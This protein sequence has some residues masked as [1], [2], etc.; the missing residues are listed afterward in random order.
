MSLPPSITELVHETA[1]L[2]RSSRYLVILT[3]AGVST[4]SGI[5][6]FRSAN[7]GLW[8][9]DDPMEVASLTS[10]LRRPER[11]YTW[12]RP[13]IKASWQ[14][15]PNPAHIGLAELEGAGIL[16]AVI[17][18]NIDGLHQRAGSKTVIEVHGSLNKMECPSCHKEF[19]SLS[20]KKLMQ[21]DSFLPT[22]PDCHTV[23]KPAITLFE[24]M[25]PRDAWLE[26]ER[27]CSQ[28]DVMMV[29]G[30]SLV[31]MPVASLPYYA[32]ENH[33]K[34]IIN[35]LSPTPLDSEACI[36]IHYDVAEVIPAIANAVLKT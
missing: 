2:I 10:Y 26:A 6:D 19:P 22:C 29:V 35:T 32:L 23:V 7:I 36:L 27:R 17:T 34:L 15:E 5:A 9:K 18:Q 24:E 8:V 16:K 12:L 11:F 21:E 28:A 30:S 20:F 31:V 4:P 13:L 33:A 25:L 3:G 1:S 14:A